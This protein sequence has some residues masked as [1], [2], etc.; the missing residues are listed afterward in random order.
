MTEANFSIALVHVDLAVADMEVLG[1][2]LHEV[3]GLAGS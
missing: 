3:P 2:V 1:G